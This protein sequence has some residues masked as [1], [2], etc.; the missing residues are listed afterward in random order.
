MKKNDTTT[1]EALEYISSRIDVQNFIEYMALQIFSGNTDT[2]NVRR[3]RNPLGDGQWHWALFDLDWAFFN[4]VD[5]ITSWLTPGGTGAGKRTDNTL[6]IACMKNPAFRDRFLTHLGEQMAT[7][8]TSENVVARIYERYER[9]ENLLPD[10]MDKWNLNLVNGPKKLVAYAKERPVKLLGYIKK[11]FNFNDA[12][13]E[14]Y[15]GA[16]IQKAKDYA[17]GKAGE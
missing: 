4:D 15:F 14:H 13:M 9:L 8:F 6:F 12:Q 11:C 17:S 16:A 2:L 10:Y 5:S 3:Y 1:D 7:V